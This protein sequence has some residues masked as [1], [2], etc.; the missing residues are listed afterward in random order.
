[1]VRKDA[2]SRFFNAFSVICFPHQPELS[3]EASCAEEN[4]AYRHLGTSRLRFLGET[5]GSVCFDSEGNYF[6]DRRR[7][8]DDI[9]SIFIAFP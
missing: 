2:F 7:P 9:Q 5:E 8:S 4:R 1:M 3:A 6:R